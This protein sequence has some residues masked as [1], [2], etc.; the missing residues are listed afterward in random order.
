MRK[1]SR[2]ISRFSVLLTVLTLALTNAPLAARAAAPVPQTAP[3]GTTNVRVT[4]TSEGVEL[5]WGNVASA[6]VAS[7]ATVEASTAALQNLPV[8]HFQG[9][10]LPMQLITLHL[11]DQAPAT[12]LQVDQMHTVDWKENLQPSGPLQPPALDW[13]DHT[14]LKPQAKSALPTSPVFII[15]EGKIHGYNSPP[16][17]LRDHTIRHRYPE[18]CLHE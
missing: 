1:F 15:R 4:T 8:E 17:T 18:V 11:P 9:Y 14:D 2:W 3:G 13:V 12:P 7:A 10:D 5:E 6:T 16:R